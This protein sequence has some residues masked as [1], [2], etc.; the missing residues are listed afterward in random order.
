MSSDVD[1]NGPPFD[2]SERSGRAR[3][4]PARSGIGPVEAPITVAV[5]AVDHISEAD[6]FAYWREQWCQGTAGVTGELAPVE[7]R[8]F[9]ARATA[10]TA[11]CVIR[12]RLETGP[13]RVSRGPLEIS[14]HSL[15]NWICLYQEMSDGATVQHAGNEFTTR[16]GDLLLT[17]PTIPFSSRPRS[18][19]DYRRWMLPRAWIEPHLPSGRRPLSAQ[20]AGSHGINGLVQAYLHALNDAI[21]ECDSAELPGIIDNFC[22][23]LALACGGG[24]G[25]QR[26][27]TRAAKLRQVK[28]YIALHLSEPDL[29]PARMAAAMKI[30]VRQL[31]LLFEPTGTSFAEHVLGRRLDECR[32]ILESP[33]SRARSIT[34]IAYTWGFNS[35]ASFYRAFRKRFGVS[36]GMVRRG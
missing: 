2:G 33:S 13:F 34:D 26:T 25:D 35:L 20:L 10:W 18:V 31:H 32:A 30:S 9:Y 29:T 3:E 28:D 27:A 11:P 22:R 8:G 21:D 16:P 12:L 7:R 23:L 6:R 14:R 17:D 4:V 1:Q 24:P 5:L 19:H 15:E 36:P